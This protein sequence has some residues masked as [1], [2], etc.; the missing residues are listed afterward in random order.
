MGHLDAGV[1]RNLQRSGNIT[2]DI[3]LFGLIQRELVYKWQANQHKGVDKAT[4][5][6]ARGA[7]V[8]SGAYGA[9]SVPA[10]NIETHLLPVEEQI[11]KHSIDTLGHI[12][13][14][15]RPPFDSTNSRRKR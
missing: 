15:E 10:L 5:L 4:S 14:T 8:I 13:P 7:P 6:Q 11:L 2:D 9:I 1:A 12:G 3:C